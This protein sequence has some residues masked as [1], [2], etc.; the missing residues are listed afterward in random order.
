ML[1]YVH[2]NIYRNRNSI[3]HK[4]RTSNL[5]AQLIIFLIYLK[6]FTSS[7]ISNLYMYLITKLST[8]NRKIKL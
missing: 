3:T 6:S 1:R 8:M 2:I 5:K 4:Y 7:Y